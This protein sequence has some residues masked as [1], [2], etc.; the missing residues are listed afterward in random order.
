MNKKD[1]LSESF[2]K[3]FHDYLELCESYQEEMP[4]PEFGFGMIRIVSKM[5]FD[6]APSEMVARET[7]RVGM[8]EGLKWSLE[9]RA[10]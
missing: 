3:L 6:I 2:N 7:I 1:D 5:L 9:E 8:E 10:K 4:A